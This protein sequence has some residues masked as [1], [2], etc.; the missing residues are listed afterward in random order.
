M[1]HNSDTVKLLD[2]RYVFLVPFFF[3]FARVKLCTSFWPSGATWTWSKCLCS[4]ISSGSCCVSSS[5]PE[6]RGSASSVWAT[7]W[8][9]STSCCLEVV[10]WCSRSGTS[11][12]CGTG[13][14]DTPA[15]WSPWRI[16]SL[17]VDLWWRI[18]T[19]TFVYCNYFS[20]LCVISSIL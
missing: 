8:P 6:P 5:S 4:V 19:R 10:C 16:Y 2:S 13:S 11:C 18:D 20:S 9:V 17:W 1:L 14:S 7:W 15:S 12:A 3:Q